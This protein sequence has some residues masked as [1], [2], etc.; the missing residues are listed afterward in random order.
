MTRVLIVTARIGAGHDLPAE[1][2][3]DALRPHAE[4]TVVDSL[5]T[6]GPAVQAVARGGLETV[7]RRAPWLFDAEYW[8]IGRRPRSRRLF[9]WLVATVGR[10]GLLAT[11]AR[12]RPDVIVSTYPG[13]T[14]ALG[15]L[16]QAGGIAC[17]C[18][19]R[20]SSRSRN[21]GRAR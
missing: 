1:L 11:I 9:Q 2:L 17:D 15:R 21:A 7:L 10:R 14:E 6:G 12:V 4:V 16:R 8:L 13:S 3:A 18:Q 5:V 19:S 20:D